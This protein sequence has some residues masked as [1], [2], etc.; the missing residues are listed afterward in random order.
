MEA[1]EICA[2]HYRTGQ[3]VVLQWR[4][5]V[6]GDLR[7]ATRATES[8]TWIAPALLDLQVNGFAGVDFQQDEL[9]A[10]E[11]LAAARRLRAAGCT[12]FLLTLVTDEWA[13]LMRRLG[14]LQQLRAAHEELNQAIAGWHIE[15]PF[16]SSDPGFYGAHN[17]ALMLDPTPDHI[18]ELRAITQVIIL[19]D[20]FE[21]FARP[22]LRQLE[23]PTLL[24]HKLEVVNDR[25][26]NYRLRI[27]DQKKNAVAALKSLNYNVIA[28]G[29]SFNDT[30]MLMEA[31]VGYLFRSPANVQTQFPQF[32]AVEEY[33]DLFRLI[34]EAM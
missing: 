18:R 12:R 8:N 7:T 4:E 24:C 22:L 26:V 27:S 1:G 6:I 14:A 28:A 29:D 17:P 23:W 11:L 5:G 16:L 33:A 9:T 15:G 32:Q 30:A 10:E 21:E 31:H 20:T 13:R 2:R 25:I 3:S 34:K 19:S